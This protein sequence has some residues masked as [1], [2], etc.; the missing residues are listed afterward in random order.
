MTTSFVNSSDQIAYVFTKSLRG[1]RIKYIC[2]KF[3]AFDLYAPTWG[4][5]GSVANHRIFS[6]Y[7]LVYLLHFLY[8][9]LL[10]FALYFGF[11]ILYIYIGVSILCNSLISIKKSIIFF[12]HFIVPILKVLGQ[13]TLHVCNLPRVVLHHFFKKSK[14]L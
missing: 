14:M 1:P 9:I 8:I 11:I 5:G 7:S 4:G 13:P 10:H 2:N 12:S 3:G 6:R